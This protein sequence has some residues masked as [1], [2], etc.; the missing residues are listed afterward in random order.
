MI[1]N[2]EQIWRLKVNQRITKYDPI[3]D[4]YYY[5]RVKSKQEGALGNRFVNII[6]FCDGV[7]TSTSLSERNFQNYLDQNPNLYSPDVEEDK[8]CGH[9]IGRH[10]SASPAASRFL[11]NS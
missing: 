6:W 3:S 4:L 11:K 1:Q 7:K 10:H 8:F 5:G 9:S 2:F